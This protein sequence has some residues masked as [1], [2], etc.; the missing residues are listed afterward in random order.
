MSYD[1]WEAYV[2]GGAVVTMMFLYVAL[3]WVV[4]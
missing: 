3:L 2:L 1:V 4:L